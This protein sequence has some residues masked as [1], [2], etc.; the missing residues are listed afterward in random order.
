MNDREFERIKSQFAAAWTRY[1]NDLV[2]AVLFCLSWLDTLGDD[3]FVLLPEHRLCMGVL[4]Y[5]VICGIEPSFVRRSVQM[6]LFYENITSENNH[7][8]LLVE[9]LLKPCRVRKKR[10]KLFLRETCL[11]LYL[12]YLHVSIPSLCSLEGIWNIGEN[13]D[14]RIADVAN[15]VGDDSHKAAVSRLLTGFGFGESVSL[16]QICQFT[17]QYPNW[18]QKQAAIQYAQ[19]RVAVFHPLDEDDI[20]SLDVPMGMYCLFE[21]VTSDKN[22][23]CWG[24]HVNKGDDVYHHSIYPKGDQFVC[25]GI[26]STLSAPSIGDLVWKFIAKDELPLQQYLPVSLNSERTLS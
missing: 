14:I 23:Y 2:G 8:V 25:P 10:I 11:L 22:S 4:F 21:D 15:S 3:S 13:G 16:E 20:R 17:R 5:A 1:A 19:N 9:F 26:D 6:S 18:Y 12:P 7:F 24:L